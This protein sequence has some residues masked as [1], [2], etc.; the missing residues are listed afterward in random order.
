MNIELT[1]KKLSQKHGFEFEWQQMQFGARRAAI[2]CGSYRE[3]DYIYNTLR[4]VKGLKV[5]T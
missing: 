1:L 4:R 5:T 3:L 2:P